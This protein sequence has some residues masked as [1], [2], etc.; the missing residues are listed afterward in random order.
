MALFVQPKVQWVKELNALN[1]AVATLA[2]LSFGVPEPTTDQEKIDFSNKDTKCLITGVGGKY[3][4]STH[5]YYNRIDL[6]TPFANQLVLLKF[7]APVTTLYDKRLELNRQLAS[8]FEE[9][10]LEDFLFTAGAAEGVLTLTAKP[11]S[12]GWKGSV[13]LAYVVEEPTVLE[14]PDVHLDGIMTP[15]DSTL[16]EQAALRYAFWDFKLNRAFIDTLAVGGLTTE[17]AEGLVA[18][19]AEIDST[20]W[21]TATAS[22][23]SLAGA[24]ILYNGPASDWAISRQFKNV[25]V[26]ELSNQS[27][28]MTGRLYLHYNDSEA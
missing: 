2:D 19:F 13:Q 28:L 24:Q 4:G 1:D 3:Y 8:T 21:T 11:G 10:D 22:E 9:A 26:I 15:N 20:P 12:Y 23:Y 7:V 6:S 16:L 14:I 5:I 17:Q 27:T 18:I 25:V